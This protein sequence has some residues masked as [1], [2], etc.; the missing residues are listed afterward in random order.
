MMLVMMV[1]VVLV[2]P[3][4]DTI[5]DPVHDRTSSRETRR[6]HKGFSRAGV[7]SSD[8]V[9]HRSGRRVS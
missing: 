6:L 2:M 9:R 7:E 1:V 3:G 5:G 8:A 4:V